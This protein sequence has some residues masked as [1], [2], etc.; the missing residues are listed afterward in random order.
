MENTAKRNSFTQRIKSMLKV[1]G[2]RMFSTLFFYILLGISFVV[3]VL[4]LVMTAM[5]DG[6]VSTAPD[7]TQTIIEGFDNVWQIIGSISASSDSANQATDI[8]SMC[9]I[10]LMFFFVAVLVCVFVS[11]DFKS[12][13]VKNLFSVRVKKTDYIISKTIICFLCSACMF[14]AFFLGSLFGGAVAGL[15]FETVG[16]GAYNILCCMLSKIMLIPVFVSIF[17]LS[18]VISKQRT[19]LSVCL[20]L[21]TGMLLFMMIP[22]LTPLNANL[23]NVFGCLIGGIAFGIGVGAISNVVLNK[24]S[25]V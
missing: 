6:S 4:I 24:T 9:N 15:P 13:Y 2:R 17:I 16:F 22:L 3:P 1:D 10:N 7:G 25:L 21:G 12:G 8:V 11:E 5:M 14:V 23:I 18:S 19:W 20:S